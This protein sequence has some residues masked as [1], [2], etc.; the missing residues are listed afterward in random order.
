MTAGK[1]LSTLLIQNCLNQHQSKLSD[2]TNYLPTIL[3]KINYMEVLQDPFIY[4]RK[5]YNRTSTE[6][7][8]FWKIESF[9]LQDLL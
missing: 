8:H 6:P 9:K 2:S 4:I 7:K 3:Y 1:K 5:T